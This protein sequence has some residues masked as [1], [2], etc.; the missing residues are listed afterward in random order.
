EEEQLLDAGEVAAVHGVA[1]D[2]EVLRDELGGVR[3]VGMDAADL[4]GG[5][6]HHVR[7][8]RGEKP[9]GLFLPLEIELVAI[10]RNDLT[11]H[12]REPSHDGRADHAAMTGDEN[13]LAGEVENLV[14]HYRSL[15]DSFSTTS[16]IRNAVK[17]PT[18]G[19]SARSSASM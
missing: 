2:G 13:L 11:G 19:S 15:S 12:I 14:R 18:A 8:G 16:I 17:R 6:D 4:G 7:P 3:V 10:R 1:G 9:L 5:H